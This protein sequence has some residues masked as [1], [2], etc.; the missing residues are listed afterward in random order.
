MKLKTIVSTGAL[1]LTAA[2]TAGVWYGARAQAPA[3]APKAPRKV[4]MDELHRGG[5]VPSGWAFTLPPG[6]DAARGRQLFRELECYKCHTIAGGDFP[7]AAADAKNTGPALTG[8]GGHHPAEYF[9]ESIVSPNAVIVE[10]PGYTGDDGLSIMPSY[11]DTLSVGQLL[12]LVAYLKSLTGGGHVHA[13]A[14][15]AREKVIG[16]YRIRVEYTGPTD[17]GHA[18]QE[19]HHGAMSRAPAAPGSPP[20]PG[21]S[22]AK[23][24]AGHLAVF[25]GTADT[26]EAVPYLPVRATFFV[27]G[28]PPRT[29]KLVPMLDA[30]GV[31][32]GADVTIP[33]GTDTVRLNIGASTAQTMPAAKGRFSTPTTAVFEWR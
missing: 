29:V 8:M 28:K 17:G 5:G 4:T 20:A 14:D 13:A 15:G 26:G 33:D 23:P 25:I 16:E 7:A 18:G 32:Y 3:P 27:A 10:G 30:N 11:A 1:V 24:P 19:A 21:T 9:A 31:H 6:G 12:D 2:L 22:A